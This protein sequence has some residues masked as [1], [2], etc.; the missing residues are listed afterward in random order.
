VGLGGAENIAGVVYPDPST[1][2]Q[3][4]ANYAV[5]VKLHAA[6]AS[7]GVGDLAS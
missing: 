2:R 5:F 6:L 4:Q 7:T 1:W 3:H